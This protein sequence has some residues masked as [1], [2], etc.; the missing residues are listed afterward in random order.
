MVSEECAIRNLNPHIHLVPP[1][2]RMN[3]S[4]PTQMKK[5]PSS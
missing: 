5:Q 2:M 3:K 4:K 1:F